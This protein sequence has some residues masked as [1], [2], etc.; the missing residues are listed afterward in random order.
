[1]KKINSRL[2]TKT[3]IDLIYYRTERQGLQQQEETAQDAGLKL[4]NYQSRFNPHN[5][6]TR[7]E[8]KALEKLETITEKLN[9]VKQILKNWN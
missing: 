1:M 5:I 3:Q 8:L 4:W 2:G 7:P 9:A 6:R